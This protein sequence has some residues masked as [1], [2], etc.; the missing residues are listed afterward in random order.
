MT[1]TANVATTTLPLRVCN[2]DI[3]RKVP[4]F[5]IR[6]PHGRGTATLHAKTFF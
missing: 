6:M 4:G 1:S 3:A 5:I 2:T